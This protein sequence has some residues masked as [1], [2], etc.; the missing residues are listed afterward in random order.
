MTK[1]NGRG[2][3]AGKE[4]R[5]ERVK[6]MTSDISVPAWIQSLDPSWRSWER[7]PPCTPGAKYHFPLRK[8]ETAGDRI[9]AEEWKRQGRWLGSEGLF[10]YCANEGLWLGIHFP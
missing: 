2:V 3:E 8:A 1:Q 7:V 6:E 10:H 5:T 9:L 4:T